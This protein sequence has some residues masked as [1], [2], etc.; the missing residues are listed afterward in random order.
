MIYERFG[1]SF[2]D[3]ADL[4]KSFFEQNDE[5]L[6]KTY[7]YA[8]IYNNQPKR[9]E[10][11][12][13][14]TRLP[15]KPDFVKHSVPYVVCK[16]CGHL[17]G[18]HEDTDA[19]CEAVYTSD[20]G[21]GYHEVYSSKDVEAYD[22]RKKAIYQ[23]KA[24]FM[25]EA[26]RRCGEDPDTMEFADMG[27]GAGYFVSAMRDLGRRDTRGY[28]VGKANVDLGNWAMPD[29]PLQLIG[30]DDTVELCEKLPV[31]VMSFVGVFEH[32]QSPRQILAAMKR[33]PK[34]KYFFFC[35][36]MFGPCIYNEMVFPKVMPRQLAIGHTH[37]FT[38]SS[39]AH[40]E[41]EFG[42]EAVAAWWFGTDVMD[43]FRSVQ[44]SLKAD[45]NVASMAEPW[46][47]LFENI[48]DGMQLA[49]DNER[50]SGQVHML[51]RVHK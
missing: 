27:A 46:S 6:E 2:R 20:A 13:C 43:Y 15:N 26:L 30:L 9:T 3:I 48:L 8:E 16:H 32:V 19:F 28:E 12:I 29:Q 18:L 34:V 40:F 38:K 36:P 51:M 22:T 41:K 5:L 1:K 24:D 44:V 33:N 4:K 14:I 37:L 21:K 11:K 23:P 47:E 7:R 42:L 35:V 45:P 25:L 50:E 17:N 31:D 10:C 39:I 49:I